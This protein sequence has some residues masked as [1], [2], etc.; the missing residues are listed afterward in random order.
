M[1]GTASPSPSHGVARLAVQGASAA[2]E[3]Q[4]PTVHVDCAAPPGGDGRAN[5]PANSLTKVVEI[6]K[7]LSAM[8]SVTIKLTVTDAAGLT[9]SSQRSLNIRNNGK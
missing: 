6:A 7:T 2:A 3:M 1:T 9:G 4:P 5:A 8:Y